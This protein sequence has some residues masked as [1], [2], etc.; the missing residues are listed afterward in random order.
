MRHCP[1]PIAS[2]LPHKPPMIL[3]D[4]IV[5]YDDNSLIAAVTITEASLFLTPDGVPGH[6]GIEY[7]A[8]ACGAYAGV[9]ALDSGDPVR[10][11]LLLGT[12]DYRVLVP[13]F[14]RGDQL[15]ISVAMVFRDKP[16][17]VFACSITIGGKIVADA[18]LKVYQSDDD[19]L[20]I[21]Q[22]VR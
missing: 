1:H 15:R 14:R 18:Q 2:L 17:A 9:H 16:L 3:I 4:E 19:Q 10:I 5:G 11:G 20:R 12:R 21:G 6:V 7:L 8:Q 22:G 13:W